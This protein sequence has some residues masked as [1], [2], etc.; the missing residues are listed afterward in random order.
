MLDKNNF[1]VEFGSNGRVRVALSDPHPKADAKI[2]NV[3]CDAGELEHIAERAVVHEEGY[4]QIVRDNKTIACYKNWDF[5]TC[6][7]QEDEIDQEEEDDEDQD[8]R[9]FYCGCL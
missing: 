5:F 8:E 1:Q 2:F 3:F 7:D 9:K 6:T 4:L